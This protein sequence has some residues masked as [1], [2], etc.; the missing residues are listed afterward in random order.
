MNSSGVAEVDS[1]GAAEITHA[2]NSSGVAEIDSS[3]AAEITHTMDSSGAAEILERQNEVQQQPSNGTNF[4]RTCFNGLNALSGV[5]ILSIPYALAQGGWLSSVFLFL[6]AFLCWYTGLLLRRCMDAHPLIKTYPDIGEHAFGYK[7]RVI[8]SVFLYV[9]LYLVAV[10][11][12]ILEGDNMDKLFPNMAFKVAGMTIGGKQAFVILTSLV[13]L[14][15]TWLKSLGLLAY[16]SAGG[17]LASFIIVICIF[18]IGAVDKVGFNESGVTLNWSGIPIA[19]SMFSFCYCGHTI[20]PTLCSSMRDRS[21]FSKV[22]LVCFITS[23]I[24]YGSMAVMGYLMYGE[25]VKSQVTLNLPIKKLSTKIAIY[26]TLINPLTKYAIIIT[27]IVTA[28]EE[29]AVFHKSRSRSIFI[30]T[31]IVALTI[32]FFDYVM[33]FIGSFSGV[34]VSMLLPCLCY[35][36]LNKTARKFGLESIVIVSILDVAIGGDIAPISVKGGGFLEGTEAIFVDSTEGVV[37]NSDSSGVVLSPNKFE[38]LCNAVVEHEPI[39]SLRKNWVAAAGRVL[40]K[41]IELENIQKLLLSNPY[42][43]LI[44]REKEVAGELKVLSIAEEKF[45]R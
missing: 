44:V 36:K 42:G 21:K 18:W 13:V 7:G 3:G 14:P 40:V 41:Q 5:G 39:A 35:P 4:L 20:F 25:H 37:A 22:L 26:T 32:P 29:N 45:F 12:L 30:S 23:T 16:F 8:V 9:E 27:P 2:M 28:I 11:F 1:S 17:V 31:V 43:E 15:T 33:A 19:I 38:A 34:T 10:E 24:N 6:V